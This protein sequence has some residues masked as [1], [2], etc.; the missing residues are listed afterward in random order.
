MR[1]LGSLLTAVSLVVFLA[2]QSPH[3]V[4]HVF[5]EHE[6]PAAAETCVLAAAAERHQPGSSETVTLHHVP[7]RGALAHHATA[8]DVP[9]LATAPVA[10]RA[11]PALLS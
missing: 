7:D 8:A 6:A 2:A 1:R 5:D 11:P 3:L 10:A 9:L 4:H